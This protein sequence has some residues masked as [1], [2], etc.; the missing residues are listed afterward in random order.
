M[1]RIESGD[2]VVH[3]QHNN[4]IFN[5]ALEGMTASRWRLPY[6]ILSWQEPVAKRPKRQARDGPG[7]SVQGSERAMTV[8]SAIW[9]SQKSSHH[10]LATGHETRTCRRDILENSDVPEESGPGDH[11]METG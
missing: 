9:R 3:S 8:G 10:S 5:L 2:A 1:G 7:D 6:A 11:E 4:V